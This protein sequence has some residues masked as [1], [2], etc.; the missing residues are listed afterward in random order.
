[1]QTAT[2]PRYNLR[3]APIVSHDSNPLE[4]AAQ[5]EPGDNMCVICQ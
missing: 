5:T 3:N 1:M 4:D 2:M